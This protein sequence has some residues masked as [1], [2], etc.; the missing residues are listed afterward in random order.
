MQYKSA[1]TACCA[2]GLQSLNS[3]KLSMYTVMEIII[4]N[5][6]YCTHQNKCTVRTDN[7]TMYTFFEDSYSNL[8]FRIKLIDTCTR[9][10]KTIYSSL[11]IQVNL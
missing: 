9:V 1:L 2:E 7:T 10:V 3:I 8:S 11:K 5:N 4:F 6:A